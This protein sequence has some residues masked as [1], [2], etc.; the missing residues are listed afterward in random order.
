MSKRLPPKPLRPRRTVRPLASDQV[1]PG[2]VALSLSSQNVGGQPTAEDV[3]NEQGA[4]DAAA[5]TTR[6]QFLTEARRRF[7]MSADAESELRKLMLEDLQFYNSDQWPQDILQNRVLDNQVSLTINRL[8]QF[9]R[10]VVNQARESKPSIQVNPVD[11]G[12][13]PDTAEVLQGIMRHIERHS[14]AHVAYAT[15]SEHQA[16]MGRGWWRVL[17]E[18]AGDDSMQQEIRIKRV[19]DAFTVYPDP[20]CSEPDHSDSNFCFIIERLP[21]EVFRAKY[22]DKVQGGG[23]NFQSIGDDQPYWVSTDG[24][25]VAE[26]YYKEAVRTTIAEILHGSG[27]D[28]PVRITVPRA[29]IK[30]D[31]LKPRI[32][33]DGTIA[34]PA[35]IILK[36]RETLKR[37]VKWA[38]ITGTDIIDGNATRTGGRD[39]P[40][41]YIPVVPVIGEELTV[42]GRRNLRGMVRDAI[43]PQR[44]Y[45]YWLSAITQKLA[46]STK[47]PI[48]AAMGQLEGHEDKWKQAN[49]RNFAF[50]EYNAVTAEGHLV[51]PPAR[52]PYD[53]DIRSSLEMTLQ[54]DRDLKSVIGMFDASQERSQEQSGKAILARQRQGEQGTSHFL[55]NL[56]RSIEHTGRILLEWIPVYYD[57]PRM[58]RIN[59][60]DEQPFDA[61]IHAGNGAAAAQMLDQ[62]AQSDQRLAQNIKSGRPFDLAVGRYDVTISVGPS[63]QSRRQEAVESI[64]GLVQAYPEWLP[65]VGDVLME[66]MDWP[67]ARQ[68][69]PRLKRLVPAQVKDPEEGQAE[70]PPEVQQQMAAMQHQLEA[71]LAALAEKDDII[72]TKAQEL[73]AQ[74]EIKKFEIQS[75]ERLEMLREENEMAKQ[76]R[77]ITADKQMALFNARLEE[78]ALR[79]GHAHEEKM[80]LTP[81]SR[82]HPSEAINYKDA[83]PDIRRQMEQQAGMTPSKAAEVSPLSK[84]A[85]KPPPVTKPAAKP[86]SGSK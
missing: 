29:S 39:V 6:D 68:L 9:V 5:A 81:D 56:S 24:I 25:Q 18:Y 75:K 31:D 20:S 33:A 4:S 73:A 63:Y 26:Y 57:Q 17:A 12:A 30:A 85:Q 43:S 62:M 82:T 13:D 11:N 10:Q 49:Y 8:P 44:A 42:N 41:S 35:V 71:A 16:I 69:V 2:A 37:Q 66:N 38:L 78:I 46:L 45:N 28:A 1:Q 23:D 80:A 70:I 48:I 54:A 59:G 40:G 3:S 7:R 65:I 58:L 55:D 83:P 22:G 64:I 15:G 47:A 77:Q 14:R 53:P 86:K 67:G 76:T 34:E 51:G 27:T 52:N 19:M 79:L 21:R 72:R 50:L 61:L 32:A 36:E 60:I 74:G 84:E